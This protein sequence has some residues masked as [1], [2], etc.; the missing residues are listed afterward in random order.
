MSKLL[1]PIAV[2]ICALSFTVSAGQGRNKLIPERK[3]LRK[4]LL[5]KY[6]ANKDGKLNKRERAKISKEDKERL[7]KAVLGHKKRHKTR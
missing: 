3:A 4:E 1:V 6:D 7:E 2:I 5:E